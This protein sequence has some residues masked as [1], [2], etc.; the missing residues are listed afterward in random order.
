MKSFN[1]GSLGSTSSIATATNSK[2]IKAIEF[3]CP[4]EACLNEF[5]NQMRP[6]FAV[7]KQR[8]YE[9]R[10]LR[11]LRDALLP[12]LMS[13]RIR[14]PEARQAVEDATDVELSEVSGV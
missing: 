5:H 7:S 14:V 4:E 9:T 11:K 12:E 1:Y 3:F 10:S 13:G 8:E 6:L 2:M